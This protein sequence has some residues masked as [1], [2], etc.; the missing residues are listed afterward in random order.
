M[1][2]LPISCLENTH[3]LWSP[4]DLGLNPGSCSCCR[5]WARN[6]TS[7]EPSFPMCKMGQHNLPH[8][9]VVGMLPDTYPVHTLS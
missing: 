5:T 1:G 9:V 8:R 4:T 6:F 2:L 7:A 3:G